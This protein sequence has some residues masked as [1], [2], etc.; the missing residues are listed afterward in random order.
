MRTDARPLAVLVERFEGPAALV[1]REVD[2]LEPGA[3]E[4]LIEVHAAGVNYPDLLVSHGT[5]QDLYPLPFVIGKEGAGV[6]RAL[7]P[8]PCG[9]ALGDRVAFQVDAGAFS[10]QV[11]VP[12]NQCYPVPPEWASQHWSW[13]A[14]SVLVSSQ[15]STTHPR[16]SSFARMARN[17]WST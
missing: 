7:G 13:G 3:G 11:I 2:I 4:L 9:F 5:Y 6:V 15:A 17:L 10:E 16:R 12:A 1:L 8:N 14:H